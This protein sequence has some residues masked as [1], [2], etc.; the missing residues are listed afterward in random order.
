M[1]IER[2]G[3]EHTTNIWNG[4]AELFADGEW[5]VAVVVL[6][7]SI[8]APIAKL[9]AMLALSMPRIIARPEHRA[10]VYRL[11]EWIGRWGMVDVLL[12]ALL[13]AAV[14]LGSWVEVSPG[15]GLIAF[16]S[17]VVLSLISTAVFDPHA[18]WEIET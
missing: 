4:V 3:H 15:P 8:I 12:V 11:V 14:K 17:V 5:I 9:S 7:C 2:L 10:Q 1:K 6:V 13:V 18:I 16:A